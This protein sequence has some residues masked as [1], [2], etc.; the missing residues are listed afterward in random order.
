[1]KRYGKKISRGIKGS[2]FLDNGCP[3]CG[4]EHDNKGATRQAL[5]KEVLEKIKQILKEEEE[6]RFQAM[7]E[8]A[9]FAKKLTF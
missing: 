5:K 7:V 2:R 6:A 3:C 4:R 1:M 9:E 8:R